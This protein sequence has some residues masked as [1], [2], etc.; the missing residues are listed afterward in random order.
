MNNSKTVSVVTVRTVIV[1]EAGTVI[2]TVE[3]V[4]TGGFNYHCDGQY[5]CRTCCNE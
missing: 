1:I 3:A 5:S 2:V 4:T